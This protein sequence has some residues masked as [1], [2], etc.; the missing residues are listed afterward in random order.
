MHDTL[1]VKKNPAFGKSGS[2][3]EVV[4]IDS[5]NN[6]RIND[7]VAFPFDT[8][9]NIVN[10]SYILSHHRTLS[11]AKKS[12]IKFLKNMMIDFCVYIT[13]FHFS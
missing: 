10:G 5:A 12:L 9:A 7:G 1:Y 3:Y 11:E 8:S 4:W 13:M 2:L 6:I